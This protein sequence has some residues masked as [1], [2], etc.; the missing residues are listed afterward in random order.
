M[1]FCSEMDKTV[2]RDVCIDEKAD[3]WITMEIEET[4]IAQDVLDE[5]E[6]GGTPIE[7][8]KLFYLN[9]EDKLSPVRII[10]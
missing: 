1:L 8:K 5:I 9:K 6:D 3:T 7:G 4:C 2:L 10:F